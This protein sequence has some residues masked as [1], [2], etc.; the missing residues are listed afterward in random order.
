M[1]HP[2]PTL[3][4]ERL[5]DAL[6]AFLDATVP[7]C[8]HV[9]Y[10]VVGTGAALLHGVPLPAADI[11]I[12]VKERADV[13]A[14]DATLS[15][16]P[17]LVSPVWLPDSRQ[18]YAGYDVHGVEVEL[19]TVEIDSDADTIETF[20]R[21]PWEHYVLIPCG[22][23]A[24]PTVALELRLITELYRN[25]PDRIRPLI[26]FMRTHGCDQG[27]IGRG[28]AAAGL[29]KR[30]RM[31]CSPGSRRPH[32]GLWPLMDSGYSIGNGT[33]VEG[34]KETAREPQIQIVLPR[35]HDDCAL[36]DLPIVVDISGN[37]IPDLLAV[38]TSD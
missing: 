21:G 27:F 1:E 14:L 32:S 22:R 3:S 31:T 10:R 30:C 20:G 13:D 36:V 38:D 5:Q 9:V 2:E 6:I 7:T 15:A 23:Y 16:Y 35:A 37:Q 17:C 19:S 33:V 34:F 12:L 29:P 18:Y 4:V 8:A 24:V 26:E 28:I 11:D 25:R